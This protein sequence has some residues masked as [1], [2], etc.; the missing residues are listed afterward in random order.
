MSVSDSLLLARVCS[1]YVNAATG[2]S[3]WDHPLEDYYKGL[4]HMKKGCQELVDKAKMKQPPSEEEISE[5]AEYF[6][7]DLAKEHYCRCVRSSVRPR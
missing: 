3:Q 5:M 7:V 4:I 6:G 1:Y 2:K